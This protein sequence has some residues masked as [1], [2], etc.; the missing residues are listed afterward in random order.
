[1]ADPTLSEL[2]SDLARYR[3]MLEQMYERWLDEQK[4]PKPPVSSVPDTVD[5]AVAPPSIQITL[6]QTG[7]QR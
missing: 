1:M 2:M 3:P 6:T 7:D 5:P 4:Q